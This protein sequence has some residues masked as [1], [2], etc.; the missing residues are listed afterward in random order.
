MLA[1]RPWLWPLFRRLRAVR[2]LLVRRASFSLPHVFVLRLLSSSVQRVLFLSGA[3]VRLRAVFSRRHVFV[4]RPRVCVRRLLGLGVHVAFEPV[5]RAGGRLLVLSGAP[6][7]LHV[8]FSHRHVLGL[9]LRACARRLPWPCVHALAARVLRA[10]G[11]LLV[12]SGALVRLRA[13]F[14]LR[15]ACGPRLHAFS[16]LQCAFALRPF[17]A[18]RCRLRWAKVRVRVPGPL[19]EVVV[20]VWLAWPGLALPPI[21][22]GPV[23][24]G[25]FVPG[26]AWATAARSLVQWVRVAR[27]RQAR[28]GTRYRFQPQGGGLWLAG[29]AQ[30]LAAI[31]TTVRPPLRRVGF[32]FSSPRPKSGP[33]SAGRA[34]AGPATGASGGGLRG[35]G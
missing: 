20:R 15:R 18:V 22:L 6:V 33:Q 17:F 27:P 14:S 31:Q 13:V 12:L 28:A 25:A 11:R 29:R 26:A 2:R 1:V 30:P 4:L 3:L 32:L 9:R 10:G 23:A 8:V 35:A 24:G 19:A 7:R 21:P 5:L 34:P 16:V